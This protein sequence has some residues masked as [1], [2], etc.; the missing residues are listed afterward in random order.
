MLNITKN[1]FFFI[2]FF[3]FCFL[4]YSKF[5]VDNGGFEPQTPSCKEGVLARL[6]HKAQ[7]KMF[8]TL[9]GV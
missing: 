8:H 4:I 5:F 6:H 3:E 7:F 2:T 1:S 9:L